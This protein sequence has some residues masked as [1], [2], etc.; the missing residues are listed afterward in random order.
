MTT[1]FNQG[2]YARIRA[3]KNEPLYNLGAKAVQVVKKG[4]FVTPATPNT[5]VALVMA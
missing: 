5:D 3:K 1:K 4:V 2:M